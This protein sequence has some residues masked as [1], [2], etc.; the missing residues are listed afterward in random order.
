MSPGNTETRRRRS[1]IGWAWDFLFDI[2]PLHAMVANRI[3]LGGTMF[4]FYLISLPSY[5]LLYGADSVAWFSPFRSL[6]EPSAALPLYPAVQFVARHDG[7]HLVWMLYALVLLSALSF[8]VGFRT[9]LAGALTLLLHIFFTTVN[10]ETTWSWATLV[11]SFLLYTVLAPTGR[12]LS[13]DA[14]LRSRRRA[15]GVGP[16]P[17][18]WTMEAWPMRLLQ[19]NVV[20]MYAVAG[21]SRID[22]PDWLEGKML[23][24]ALNNTLHARWVFDWRVYQP[25][26]Q[27]LSYGTFILEP[28]ATVLLAV[29]VTRRWIALVLIGMHVSLELLTNVGWWN[30]IMIGGLLSFLPVNWLRYPFLRVFGD[31][32]F[33]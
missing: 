27:I 3:I 23:F 4:A 6:V 24:E 11:N 1:P 18:R 2:R 21:W 15:P 8:C 12:V 16:D 5:H 17:S 7:Q 25:L 22:N 29:R 14:W 31:R 32:R 28:L 20:T 19:I 13:V 26:L 33:K 9:R 10:P 30:Y